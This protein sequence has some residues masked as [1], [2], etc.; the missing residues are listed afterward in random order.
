[1][2]KNVALVIG[3]SSGI[4]LSVVK[5]LLDSEYLVYN[6]SRSECQVPEV[7]NIFTDAS[8]NGQVMK[9]INEV[10]ET[11]KRLDLLI[12]VAGFSMASPIEYVEEK[13]YRYLFEVN[14]FSVIEAFKYVIP[15][16]KA[17]GHGHIITVSSLGGSI[18]IP[19]DSFY[20]ASKAALDMFCLGAY[21]ELKP[22]NIFVT[23][24]IPG[25]VRTDFTFKRMSYDPNLFIDY[26]EMKEAVRNLALIEQNG[27]SSFLVA[28][29]IKKI[30]KHQ[31]PPVYLVPGIKDKLFYHGAKI[32]SKKIL[33]KIVQ[34]KYKI[35]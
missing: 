17:Q 34:R 4:G 18:I 22:N 23:N 2:E 28:K 33:L 21:L 32:M 26:F 10:F 24:I 8:I 11:Q 12:Y 29:T 35:K 27:I 25:G 20:S 31:S 1:M 15:I 14:F 19:F 30:L 6:A 5:M 3:G 9:A 13:D 16:M 7:I